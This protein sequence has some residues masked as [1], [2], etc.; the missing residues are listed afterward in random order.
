MEELN[1]KEPFLPREI[2]PKELNSEHF[3]LI[4]AFG[5]FYLINW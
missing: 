2:T 1:L 4:L 3:T 5:L